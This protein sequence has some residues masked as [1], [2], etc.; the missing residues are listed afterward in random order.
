MQWILLQFLL[1][2]ISIKSACPHQDIPI[3]SCPDVFL[4]LL[5][6]CFLME[7]WLYLGW[8]WIIT[9][10]SGSL[11]SWA[12]SPNE[13]Q[14]WAPEDS[15]QRLQDEL[16][17]LGRPWDSSHSLNFR[18]LKKA[19]VKWTFADQSQNPDHLLLLSLLN[20]NHS[21]WILSSIQNQSI[22]KGFFFYWL[23]HICIWLDVHEFGWIWH[24]T[25]Q[26]EKLFK[27][28]GDSA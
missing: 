17:P 26:K 14:G 19:Q 9:L 11:S 4:L 7:I 6:V 8:I 24:L 27:V 10:A 5:F 22:V 28:S 18:K 12:Q 2:I 1:D 23:W 16:Q 21:K 3:I 15:N 13:P 25:S 20:N